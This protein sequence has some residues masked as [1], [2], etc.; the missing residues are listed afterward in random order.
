[1]STLPPTPEPAEN[2]P[3]IRASEL[4][5]Y[6]FCQRAWWLGVVKQIPTHNQTALARGTQ[7]HR[8]HSHQ[9]R[10]ALRWRQASF[11]LLVGGGLL[12]SVALAW[13]FLQ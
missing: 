4:T 10:A 13:Y 8:Q 12:L 2:M 1:M 5:Q 11:F 9:V 6:S 3:L 7:T